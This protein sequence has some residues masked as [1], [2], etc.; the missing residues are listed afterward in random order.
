MKAVALGVTLAVLAVYVTVGAL[1]PEDEG[2]C[3]SEE[4]CALCVAHPFCGWCAA[5]RTCRAGVQIEPAVGE[6]PLVQW[7]FRFCPGAQCS[8]YKQCS[9]CISDPF[10]GWCGETQNCTIGTVEGPHGPACPGGWS[11][12]TCSGG[13]ELVEVV[14]AD[15]ATPSFLELEQDIEGLPEETTEIA[16]EE[17]ETG[18]V[19]A[20]EKEEQEEEEEESAPLPGCSRFTACSTCVGDGRCGWCDNECTEGTVRGPLPGTA[21]CTSWDWGYCLGTPCNVHAHCVPCTQDPYCGWCA[22]SNQ[23]MEGNEAGP[24]KGECDAWDHGRCTL[25]TSFLQVDVQGEENPQ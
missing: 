22:E 25:A 19:A 12:N 16:T 14:E 21:N 8:V 10:C 1:S 11:L 13:V 7:H 18:D 9:S 2:I 17:Q 20:A 4:D 23:C 24:L 5:D 3:R 15:F 6:C